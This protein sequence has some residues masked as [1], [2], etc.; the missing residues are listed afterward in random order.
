MFE[1]GE[2][3]GTL[4]ATACSDAVDVPL[5][6][7]AETPLCSTV[8]IIGAVGATLSMTWAVGVCISLG[9][10]AAL[11]PE[12]LALIRFLDAVI[13]SSCAAGRF[14]PLAGSFRFCVFSFSLF[15]CN[16]CSLVGGD[17][18]ASGLGNSDT[19]AGAGVVAV[20]GD[21]ASVI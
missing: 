6:C 18:D 14:L 2:V 12:T 4:S 20:E 1:G 17:R 10:G 9:E 8:L 19:G 21:E 11:D 7:T 13:S 3:R 5:C 16:R 15:P